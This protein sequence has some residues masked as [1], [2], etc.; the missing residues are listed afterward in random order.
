MKKYCLMLG[1]VVLLTGCVSGTGTTKPVVVAPVAAP[2]PAPAPVAKA[3]APAPAPVQVVAP[4]P[5]RDDGAIKPAV[6]PFSEDS[7]RDDYK[8]TPELETLAQTGYKLYQEGK[9]A[10]TFNAGYYTD[11]DPNSEGKE[12][13]FNGTMGKVD[14]D[15][16]NHYETIYMWRKEDNTLVYVGS[17]GPRRSYVDVGKGFEAYLGQYFND[18]FLRENMKE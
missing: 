7:I 18:P 10:G 3:P 16:N 6:V 1:F 9:T 5:A 17:M 12:F 11:P 14:R 15:H 13:W 2:A 8:Y 4:V